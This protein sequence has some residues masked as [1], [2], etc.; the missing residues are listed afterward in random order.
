MCMDNPSAP[1]LGSIYN[2]SVASEAAVAPQ[3]YAENAAWSPQYTKLGLS[4][5]S[6]FLNGSDGTPG[7]LSEYSSN[8]MPTLTASQ[9]GANSALRSATVQD[10][11]NLTPGI[12]ANERAANP[13]AA[14]MVDTL[15]SRTGSD[16]NLGTA[17]NP[18]ENRL[19]QQQVRGG[20]TARGLGTG[21]GD[22]VNEAF[23]QS[24]AGQQLYQ[25]RLGNAQ[26]A[27]GTSMGFYKDPY[28]ELTGVG[29]GSGMNASAMA[30]LA[31][32]SVAPSEMS[33]FSPVNAL[34]GQYQSQMW[35]Q[36]QAGAM[37]NNVGLTSMAKGASSY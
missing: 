2:S 37:N 23:T 25:Q 31:S 8:I 33:Q 34:S 5:L 3:I 32:G 13:G 20:E 17:L 4:N 9:I 28:A 29:S 21:A 11:A 26:N 10:A 30:G 12:I 22:A 18:N 19:L 7:F 27:V 14:S 24:N 6:S 15:L 1:A 36:S 16:L 35:E